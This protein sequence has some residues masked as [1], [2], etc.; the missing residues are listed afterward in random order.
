[1]LDYTHDPK[2][3]E[4]AFQIAA[5][6][7]EFAPGWVDINAVTFAPYEPDDVEL[8]ALLALSPVREKI[9]ELR[10]MLNEALGAPEVKPTTPE[11]E[12]AEASDIL[13]KYTE[14]GYIDGYD[15]GDDGHLVWHHMFNNE[16][17][18]F[19]GDRTW[20]KTE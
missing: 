8:L 6:D 2:L 11:E 13:H 4:R 7:P 3:L 10:D 14:S 19:V 9:E 17:R 12:L 18:T 16:D 20:V 1:M 5:S 15:Y